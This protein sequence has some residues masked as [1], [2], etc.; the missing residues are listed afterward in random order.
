QSSRPHFKTIGPS[1]QP[2]MQLTAWPMLHK[3]QPATP[4]LAFSTEYGTSPPKVSDGIYFHTL[5]SHIEGRSEPSSFLN[6]L[7]HPF[8]LLSEPLQ[9]GVEAA[10]TGIATRKDFNFEAASVIE[11]CRHLW[12]LRKEKEAPQTL[13]PASAFGLFVADAFEVLGLVASPESAMKAW[14]RLQKNG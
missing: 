2:P 14:R 13:N 4:A 11:E 1:S 5:N 7:T 12:K 10:K 9:A 3:V 6:W 8:V